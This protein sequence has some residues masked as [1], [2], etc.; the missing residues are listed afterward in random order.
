MKSSARSPV[1]RSAAMA[2]FETVHE[3][4][5]RDAYMALRTTHRGGFWRI[6]LRE[7]LL[8][9]T[10]GTIASGEICWVVDLKLDRTGKQLMIADEA[11]QKALDGWE[12]R[13]HD[14][15]P[16]VFEVPMMGVDD[17]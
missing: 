13:Y 10:A 2:L 14:A 8:P 3:P 12:E 11:S 6:A 5:L 16:Y 4:Q 17:G 9:I 7:R 1:N 15:L